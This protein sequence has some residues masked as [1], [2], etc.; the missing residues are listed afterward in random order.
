ML[1]TSM[2]LFSWTYFFSATDNVWDVKAIG[3]SDPAFSNINFAT[4][5]RLCCRWLFQIL[6][7][8]LSLMSSFTNSPYSQYEARF[9][10]CVTNIAM[11]LPCCHT[12]VL[13]Q[14]RCMMMNICGWWWSWTSFTSTSNVL[15][16]KSSGDTS[17]FSSL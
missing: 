1:H 6:H 8:N 4:L 11:V 7:T 13:N 10:R 12:H 16:V 5:I 3:C 2:P 14:N 9:L 15:D 17:I